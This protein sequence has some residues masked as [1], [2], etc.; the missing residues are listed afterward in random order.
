MGG[1][2]T[3]LSKGAGLVTQQILYTSKLF[4][5]G[6]RPHDSVWDFWVMFDLVSIHCL[7]HVEVH[8][9]T[10]DKELATRNNRRKKGAR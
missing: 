10:F 7:A 9:E 5:E 8:A 6:A 1:R 3:V 2:H 4:G